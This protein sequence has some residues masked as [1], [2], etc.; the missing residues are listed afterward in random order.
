MVV[1]NEQYKR[2]VGECLAEFYKG[3]LHI[4]LVAIPD[5]VQGSADALRRIRDRI[6]V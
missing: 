1:T 3:K 6:K 4:D 2:E 5:D